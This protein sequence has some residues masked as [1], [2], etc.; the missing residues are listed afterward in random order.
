MLSL[1]P[2]FENDCS[3][4]VAIRQGN[5]MAPYLWVHAKSLQLCSTLCDPMDCSLPRLLHPWDAPGKNTE[6]G[7]HALLQGIFPTQESNPHLLHFLSL[8]TLPLK[9]NILPV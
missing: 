7:L 3:S 1:G 4:L 9:C 5:F 2:H 8:P 6:V